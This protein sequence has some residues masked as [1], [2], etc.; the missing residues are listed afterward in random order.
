MQPSRNTGREPSDRLRPGVFL[1][2]DGTLIEDVGVLANP[3]QIRL[4]PDTVTAL[5]SLQKEYLLFVVTNQP[6]ISSGQITADQ[7]ETVNN[8][9][10]EMLSRQGINIK[11]WYVC[12]H[13][14]EDGCGCIKPNPTFLLKA[15]EDYGVDLQRSFV[16]GD[17]PHDSFT[18]NEVGVFGLY[19]LTGHGTKHLDALPPDRLV[20]HTL[21][22]AAAWITSHPRHRADLNASV[23]AG[24]DAIRRGGVVAFPTETVY[25]LGADA[26]NA[27]AVARIYEIK[28]RPLHNP[29]I[30]HVS[31]LQQAR[32]LVANLTEGAE[33]LM[34]RFWPG[35]LTLVLPK[36]PQ[37]PEIVTA[38]NPT[39][40]IRMP[41]NTLALQLIRRAET[42]IAA[43]SANVFGRT[44]PTTAR[45]VADQLRGS[46]DVLIDGGSCRVGVESTVL[47]LASETPVLLRLGGISR[48][49]IEQIIRDVQVVQ[50]QH[51]PGIRYASPGMLPSHYAPSTPL[52]VVDRVDRY[53]HR[54]DVGVILFRA[55]AISFR[56]PV[57]ILSPNG[58]L[59]E[60]ATRLYHAMRTLDD[61]GLSRIVAERV[62]NTGLGAAI[63][64]RLSKAASPSL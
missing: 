8:S 25:G 27:D 56:G 45:H 39:V 10:D 60:A 23:Q 46:Y 28:R 1:D 6:G 21:G 54:S 31:S 5:R 61:M 20:F 63:N 22:D 35:P 15:A 43:P 26:F 36:T 19:L 18:G 51:T 32:S 41:A 42:P 9:L 38:G 57:A 48:E 50:P 44:S 62:P 17:H 40:A 4:F 47:S 34:D 64:D 16:I 58:D 13:A 37:I 29:L 55:S 33:Q 12:P 11:E 49:E 3:D 7:T 2:R 53:A 30:V 24:A 14:R 52:V 59:R